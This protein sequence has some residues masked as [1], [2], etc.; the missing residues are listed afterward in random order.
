MNVQRNLLVRVATALILLPVVLWLLWIGGLPFALLVSVAAAAC[1]WELNCLPEQGARDDAGAARRSVR[2]GVIASTAAAFLLPITEGLEVHGFTARAI[3]AALV[4]VALADA[5]LFEP[6]LVR[7]PQRIGMA[8]LGAVYPG[9]LM[10]MAVRL[11]QLPD[12]V[13]WMALTLV[14]TWLN[15][16]GAYFAGRAYGRR[17]LYPRVSPSK[18]WEGAAG[19]LVA[20]VAGALA[21]KAIGWLPQLPWWGSVVVGAGAAVLGPVGDLSE[22]MLKRAYGA[23]DSS[24][25]LPGHGG[26]L[27]R[28]D[29]LLFTAPF[30]LFCASFLPDLR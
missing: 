5:L 16:T 26:V 30:V 3:L 4:M 2:G 28:V 22:S 1:A 27:D 10:A 9:V 15:D 20:S 21:V 23:K 12:G 6:D 8:V 14:V 29:A 25:L 13:A 17:K 19:G 24:A 11:R 18:T 7:V